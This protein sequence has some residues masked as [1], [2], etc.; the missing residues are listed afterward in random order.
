MLKREVEM[1]QR[2]EKKKNR[3][4]ENYSIHSFPRSYRL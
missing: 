2:E 3:I 1:K 4:S